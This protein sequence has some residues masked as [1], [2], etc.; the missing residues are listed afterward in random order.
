VDACPR[1]KGLPN[2][3]PTKHGCPALVRVTEQEI[4]ILEQVQFKTASAEIL[5]A[6][7]DLLQQVATVLAEHPEIRR[8]EVQGHTDNRGG[9]AYNQKLSERRA[10]AVVKWLVG[11]G[12]VDSTRLV[13][14][15]FGFDVPIA[16]NDTPED[17]QKNRR[18]QFTILE[19]SVTEKGQESP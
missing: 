8:V 14:K 3:D 2:I 17:R 7:D 13:A 9:K 16:S 19:K 18:V 6:S 4:V 10:N 15:G 12:Q 5:K 11:R 1:E